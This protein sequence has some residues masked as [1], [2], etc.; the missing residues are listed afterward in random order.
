M[1][2]I[3][4]SLQKYMLWAIFKKKEFGLLRDWNPGLPNE[5]KS[6]FHCKNW[7]WSLSMFYIPSLLVSR[8]FIIGC[9]TLNET[10]VFNFIKSTTTKNWVGKNIFQS[11]GGGAVAE[12]SKALLWKENKWKSQR[13]PAWAICN[14]KLV[15]Q[16]ETVRLQTIEIF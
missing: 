2:P 1:V 4:T 13:S 11:K 7:K 9:I 16:F 15:F 3:V 10:S 14:W 8:N 6:S 5:G 12:Y